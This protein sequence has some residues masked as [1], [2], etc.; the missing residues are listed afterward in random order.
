M[1]VEAVTPDALSDGDLDT[2]TLLFWRLGD[3]RRAVLA[4]GYGGATEYLEHLVRRRYRKAALARTIGMNTKP[5]AEAGGVMAMHFGAHRIG[6]MR[7]LLFGNPGAIRAADSPF[8]IC[9]E[10]PDSE[11]NPAL[12]VL[13]TRRDD[14][15][16]LVRELVESHELERQHWRQYTIER[17]RYPLDKLLLD[18]ASG[19]RLRTWTTELECQLARSLA[20]RSSGLTA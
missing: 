14:A 5:L 13:A 20:S 3:Q 6:L 10:H 7:P 11:A 19:H 18:L 16:R 9:F 4:G 12:P 15:V 8:L 2:D 17:M 1:R